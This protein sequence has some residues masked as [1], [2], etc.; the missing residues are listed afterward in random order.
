M[1]FH[2]CFIV[3]ISTMKKTTKDC[4][5]MYID[6]PKNWLTQDLKKI[7]QIRMVPVYYIIMP[8]S[9]QFGLPDT[10]KPSQCDQ[11]PPRGTIIDPNASNRIQ[12]AYAHG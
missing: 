2:L 11:I 5:N 4:Y 3:G 12:L 9:C 7:D 1:L 8:S 10:S 6:D